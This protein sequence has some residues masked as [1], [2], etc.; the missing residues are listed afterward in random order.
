MPLGIEFIDAD[1]EK[2]Q[3]GGDI[4][5]LKDPS[6]LGVTHYTAYLSY[7]INKREV[8]LGTAQNYI[9]GTVIFNIPFGT[10]LGNKRYVNVASKVDQAETPEMISTLIVDLAGIQKRNICIIYIVNDKKMYFF[11]LFFGINVYICIYI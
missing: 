10:Y 1:F 7:T 5:I 3:I 11:S 2:G 6:E 9:N 4:I 8:K